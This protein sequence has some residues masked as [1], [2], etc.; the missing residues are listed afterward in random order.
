MKTQNSQGALLNDKIRSINEFS[1]IDRKLDFRCPSC[2]EVLIP[3]F[4]KTKNKSHF[5]HK[6]D[7]NCA[8]AQESA[9]HLMAKEVLFKTKTLYFPDFHFED[10]D[11]I[12][13][14]KDL[15]G[16]N[17]LLYSLSYDRIEMNL[18]GMDESFIEKNNIQSEISEKVRKI[19]PQKLQGKIVEF[20]DIQIENDNKS[21]FMKKYGFI[22]DAVGIIID[23]DKIAR[24]VII[25]FL[26]THKVDSKKIELIKKQ[27]LPCI[28]IDISKLE[29]NKEVF[30][31][32][33]I[34][35]ECKSTYLY[36]PKAEL[37]ITN[38]LNN[39][40]AICIEEVENARNQKIPLKN[41]KPASVSILRK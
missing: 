14:C 16:E 2:G 24:E 29:L 18:E 38:L 31:D 28:E 12:S 7:S 19:Q 27:N 36:N 23:K 35:K 6:S 8:G 10:E 39:I 21:F 11:L 4:K 15:S 25:E 41:R 22:P 30:R 40:D 17:S 34:N 13:I 32:Y 20:I 26:Y 37:I 9:Y 1:E 3:R 5:A 33:F